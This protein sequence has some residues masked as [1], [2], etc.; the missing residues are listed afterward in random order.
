MLAISR[1]LSGLS[2]LPLSQAAKE[3]GWAA[4][5]SELEQHPVRATA[6]ARPPRTGHARSWRW[7]IACA[8]AAVAVIA[9]LLG[10]YSGGLLQTVDS[11]DQTTTI[12]SVV[13]SDTTEPSTTVSTES[14]T[15][16][17]SSVPTS[18]GQVGPVSTD[19]PGTTSAPDTTTEV[20]P[21]TTEG[22]GPGT[23]G[24][25]S[26]NTTA[27]RPSSTTTAG[28]Q[29]YTSVQREGS[30]RTAAAYLADM[31]ITGNTS[32][33]RALVAP[34]AQALLAQMMTSL[35][36]PHGYRI[37][38]VRSLSDTSVRVTLEIS[39]RVVS[40]NGELK[41]ALPKFVIKVRVDDKGAVI[42]AINAG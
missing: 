26:I 16:S 14:T 19:G 13:S 12:T 25:P 40:P 11:G 22:S 4:V 7:A 21:D 27:T 1:E 37:T 33:A 31:V 28:E 23:T 24:G 8:A 29:L 10:T 2:E 3:R 18:E 42:T 35:T 5:K 20:A 32:G 30:A 39:D 17:T 38:G 36:E 9:T 41:E 6:G 15:V 34:E